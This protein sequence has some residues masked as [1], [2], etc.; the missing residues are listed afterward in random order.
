MDEETAEQQADGNMAVPLGPGVTVIVGEDNAGKRHFTDAPRLL[1]DPLEG[2]H[3]CWS[4][5]R[6]APGLVEPDDVHPWADAHTVPRR[7]Q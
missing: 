2:R 4:T 1:T 6:A 7:G 3:Q 5:R